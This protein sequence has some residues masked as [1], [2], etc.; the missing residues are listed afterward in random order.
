MLSKG[1]VLVFGD[2]I[3]D[4]YISGNVDRVS[5]EAPVPVLKPSKEEIRLGG[6]AN[7]ALNLSSLGSNTTLI[8][9]TGRDDSSI[10]INELLKKNNIKNALT[11][12]NN[13][14][15]TKLRLLAAQ[16][17]LIRI[18]NEEE[19]SE[20]DWKSS[21]S[22]YKK[23]IKLKK[24][25]VLIISDYDKGTLRDIPLL[26]KEA[27]KLNKIILVDPKGD[28]FSKYKSANIITPNF[29]EFERV[30]GKTRGEADV[31]R[32]GKELIKSLQ[33]TSLL[34]TRGSEGMTLLE[35]INGRIK[36]EDFP[37]EAKDVFDVSGAGDTVIASI[38]AG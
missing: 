4:K 17:Q 22:S 31:T 12:S 37:T 11:K 19:F 2:V 7:V 34:I 13:P 33:L 21:L 20:A 38:A 23:Q 1:N 28:D 30:V 35:S 14:T 32:K 29:H 36:R 24:N 8:G 15:I 10:Q 9:V 16:Q 25:Q 18:D 26:I 5:P 6:A 3:L 27:K